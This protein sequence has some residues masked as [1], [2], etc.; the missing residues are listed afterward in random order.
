MEI[1]FNLENRGIGSSLLT[2]I[3]IWAKKHGVINIIGDLS[4][5][6]A[7]HFD[8]L[9]YF[10]NKNGYDFQMGKADY[11]GDSIMVGEIEKNII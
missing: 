4:N 5:V 9:K 8:K 1:D 6:D 3:E 10:Y 11:N 7:D 2:L